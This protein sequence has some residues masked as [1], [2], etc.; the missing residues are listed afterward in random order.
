MLKFNFTLAATT[1][2]AT[3]LLS[4]NCF[5]AEPAWKPL[6][7]G[8][9]LA[10]WETQAD[11]DVKAVNGEIHI[12]S[13]RANLW[14]L[15][16]KSFTDFE[17]T[18][19]AHM[20][21]G[22]YNSGIGFRCNSNTGNKKQ[23]KGK[24]IQGYQCE[25]DRGKSGMVY[26]IGSGWVWPKTADEKQAFAAVSAGAFDNAKWNTFRI[27]C[28]G[29]HLQIWINGKLITSIHDKRFAAGRIA[30]Q[31]HGKGGVHRFRNVKI[32]EL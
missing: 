5:A 31:H 21:A 9:S 16:G 7:D 6:F 29:D 8:K 18:V 19:E 3:L 24:K 13:K 2:A 1:L 26:A 14:L 32:R 17:L 23:G 11:G 27:R 10:G 25:I 12:L 15:H 20:P 30:L 22:A 4:A 28:E